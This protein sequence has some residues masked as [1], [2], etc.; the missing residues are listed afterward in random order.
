[1]LPN[2]SILLCAYNE[3]ENIERTLLS[4]RRQQTRARFEIVGVDNGSTDSTNS[5]LRACVDVTLVCP[6][7]GKIPCIKS[8]LK[9]TQG[10]IVAFADADTIY[11]ENWIEEIFSRFEME[12]E[13]LFVFG[14]SETGMRPRFLADAFSCLFARASI[15]CG[16]CASTGFNMA[17]RRDVLSEVVNGIGD[18]AL[19]GWAIGTA[20]LRVYGRK[21][22]VFLASMIAPKNMRRIHRRGWRFS[23]HLWVTQWTRLATG[24]N[25]NVTESEYYEF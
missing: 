5:I 1:M 7:R 13:P 18:V 4:L 8:G 16:V 6:E 24:R 20:L 3:E 22:V 19:S 9:L 2:V 23:L 21:K 25:L 10:N 12:D 15:L 14:P 17:V 11:P